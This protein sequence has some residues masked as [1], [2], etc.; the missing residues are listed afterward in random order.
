[1]TSALTPVAI[2]SRAADFHARMARRLSDV[3]AAM[4][5]IATHDQKRGADTRAR[6]AALSH[7][8]PEWT[9]FV[10]GWRGAEG[11]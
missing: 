6:L 5:T 8:V 7:H 9:N 2:P 11:D 1:M 4:L 3:P 10:R